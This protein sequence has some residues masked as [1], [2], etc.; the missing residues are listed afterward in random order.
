MTASHL[1]PPVGI[2]LDLSKRD[3]AEFAVLEGRAGSA[4]NK[5]AIRLPS[6]SEIPHR[7]VEP[8]ASSSLSVSTQIMASIST[9]E[10]ISPMAGIQR[11]L[12]EPNEILIVADERRHA[13]V[14]A[15]RHI[16]DTASRSE[17]RSHI[18]DDDAAANGSTGAP[19]VSIR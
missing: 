3:R 4:S 5:R 16:A 11:R 12:N 7:A 1:I 19:T 2:T 17:V 10:S 6:R 8:M 9:T 18:R 13:T 15:R 14:L